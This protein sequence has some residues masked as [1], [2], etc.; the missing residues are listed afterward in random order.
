[1]LYKPRV[2]PCYGNTDKCGKNPEN[3]FPA[4]LQFPFTVKYYIFMYKIIN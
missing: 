4:I 1:M 3:I 2:R